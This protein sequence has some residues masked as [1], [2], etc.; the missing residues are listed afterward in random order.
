MLFIIKILFTR[1]Y[2]SYFGTFVCTEFNTIHFPFSRND[3]F[4]KKLGN[5]I[6]CYDWVV[7]G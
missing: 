1:K 3:L 4:A 5:A 7:T 2:K 6:F